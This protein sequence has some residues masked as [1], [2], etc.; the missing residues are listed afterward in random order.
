MAREGVP[1]NV[2]QRQL[3]FLNTTRAKAAWGLDRSPATRELFEERFGALD[4]R[5][6]HFAQDHAAEVT[7][8]DLEDRMPEPFAPGTSP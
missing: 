8:V 4:V 5:I 2:I 7:V 1:L 3:E 6:S